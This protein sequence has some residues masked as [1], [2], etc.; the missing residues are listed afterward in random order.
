M[1]QV[2]VT[3]NVHVGFWCGNPKERTNRKSW[4][5]V[6]ILEWIFEKYEG[7]VDCVVISHD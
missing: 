5:W 7:G 4:D 3:G 6:I 2:W 1:W